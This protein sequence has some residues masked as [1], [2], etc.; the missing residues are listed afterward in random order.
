VRDC[1][2]YQNSENHRKL[3]KPAR[4]IV[5]DFAKSSGS[6]GY[7][8]TVGWFTFTPPGD[9]AYFKSV[10]GSDIFA[11]LL[12]VESKLIADD[13]EPCLNKFSPMPNFDLG[14][15][16][17]LIYHVQLRQL[18]SIFGNSKFLGIFLL[19]TSQRMDEYKMFVLAKLAINKHT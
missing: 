14:P 6:S 15:V 12:N 2:R 13:N 9:N 4:P 10:N 18:F 3:Q 16:R 1:V 5:Q 17:S 11:W 19:F 8:S 7:S